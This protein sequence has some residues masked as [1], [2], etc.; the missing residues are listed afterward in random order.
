MDVIIP[1][2]LLQLVHG[3]IVLT[4][5]G[6]KLS[7]RQSKTL[8][9]RLEHTAGGS[10]VIGFDPGECGCGADAVTEVF[11]G[12]ALVQPLL[13]DVWAYQHFFHDIFSFPSLFFLF[14]LLWR[15]F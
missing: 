8:Q 11:L 5:Q 3:N 6:K 15:I 9:Q 4:K 13:P 14:I 10:A 1:N 7:G 12:P 2:F